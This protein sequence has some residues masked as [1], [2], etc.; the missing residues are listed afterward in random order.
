MK[1]EVVVLCSPS[2]IVLKVAVIEKQL[3]KIFLGRSRERAIVN[4]TNIET[5]N[6]K[7]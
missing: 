3:K 4:Q 7:H 2:L 6:E 1:V 5:V